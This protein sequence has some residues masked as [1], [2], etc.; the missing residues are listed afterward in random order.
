MQDDEK[1]SEHEQHH[2]EVMCYLKNLVNKVIRLSDRLTN[3]EDNLKEV[4]SKTQ[5]LGK[6]CARAFQM[7]KEVICKMSENQECMNDTL[8]EASG[9]ICESTWH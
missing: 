6:G 2:R 1:I 9:V 8:E 3:M 5:E 4:T 7:C